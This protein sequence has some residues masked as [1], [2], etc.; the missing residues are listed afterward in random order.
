[1]SRSKWK[2]PINYIENIKLNGKKPN[3]IISKRNSKIT[4]KFLNQTL[5]VYNG[6]SYSSIIVNEEM[7]GHSLGEFVFT[8]KKFSFKKK[9]SKK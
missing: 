5:N 4:P 1:M 8:R 9:K 6:K 3:L 7:V 2:G